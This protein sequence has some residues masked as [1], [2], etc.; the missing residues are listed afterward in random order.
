MRIVH[1][2]ERCHRYL[3]T[4]SPVSYAP[5]SEVMFRMLVR[6]RDRKCRHENHLTVILRDPNL[7]NSGISAKKA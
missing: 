1:R 7:R 2:C 3:F 4:V 5:L 6:C